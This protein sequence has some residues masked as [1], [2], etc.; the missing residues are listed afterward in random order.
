MFI[1][2][3]AFLVLRRATASTGAVNPID[4]AEN[5][6][7]PGSTLYCLPD[8]CLRSRAGCVLTRVAG[9]KS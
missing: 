7:S 4:L 1:S 9:G 3:R 6:L 8:R 2:R 5:N